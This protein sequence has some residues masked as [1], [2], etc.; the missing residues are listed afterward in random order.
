[1]LV[2]IRDFQ[3]DYMNN[4]NDISVYPK[5]HIAWCSTL[6]QMQKNK[7]YSRYVVS[8]RNDGIFLLN[9]TIVG[10]V[11]KRDI[12]LELL[13]CKNCLK[14]LAYKGYRDH[15]RN[16]NIFQNFNIKEFLNKYNTEV[17][18]DPVHTSISQPLNEYSH[19]WNKISYNYKKS[20]KFICQAC[21]KD[22]SKNTN[23]LHVHHVD[24]NKFNNLATN[25]EVVCVKCHSKKPM[26]RHM[27]TNPQIQLEQ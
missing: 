14:K 1:M 12:E 23:E 15:Q 4:D 8:Q 6:D 11:V 10:K 2:Y 25:L 21:G 13:I 18:I 24:G 9:K 5:F 22:C 17:Y 26:H 20:K 7:K 19:D 16:I 3:G 27:L